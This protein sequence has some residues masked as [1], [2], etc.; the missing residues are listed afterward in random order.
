MSGMTGT[1]SPGRPRPPVKVRQLQRRLWAAAKRSPERRFHA[2]MDRVWRADLLWAAWQRVKRNRGGAG[3]DG[4]T[5]AAV[6]QYGVERM[7]CE[8]AVA[9]R[10]G[11]YRPPP[12]LRRYIPKADGRRRPL[13]IP[14]VRDRVVQMA[15]TL[16][17]EPIF[18]ADFRAASYGF[19]PK[20][21][22][23]QALEALRVR[24]ARGGSYVLDADIQDYFA[25]IDQARLLALV[26]RRISDRRVLKLLR[27]WL[28]AGVLEA[29]HWSATGVG[30]PQGG[31]ISPL[32]AN[33]YL[34]VLDRV[35][36][37]PVCA[38]GCVGPLCR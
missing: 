30:T 31:V 10:A 11:T 5:L 26:A 21:S 7:L 27:Q 36:G 1:N 9:L 14:T 4:E 38:L 20:R 22:A 35:W 18:E 8:L 12:V 2:L 23:V 16:V 13:G 24:G 34:S 25:S 32:L 15:V 37:G 17:L 28:T 33:I 3:V 6:E 29:G 19:R